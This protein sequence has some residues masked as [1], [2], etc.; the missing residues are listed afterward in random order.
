MVVSFHIHTYLCTN[1][2]VHSKNCNK[3]PKI[4]KWISMDNKT[5]FLVIIFLHMWSA[6]EAKHFESIEYNFLVKW[7]TK[8]VLCF[9]ALSFKI[10]KTLRFLY[11]SIFHQVYP[12]NMY[13]HKRGHFLLYKRF[14]VNCII[15]CIP[16][17]SLKRNCN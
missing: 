9:V 7:F 8:W 5:C 4:L 1:I 12:M 14:E 3:V 13:F 6:F 16:F 17:N 11:D 10:F 15:L 2:L